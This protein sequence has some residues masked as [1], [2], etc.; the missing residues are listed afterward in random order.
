MACRE[1]RQSSRL[2]SDMNLPLGHKY[3][4]GDRNPC[5]AAVAAASELV[6][7][8]SLQPAAADPALPAPLKAVIAADPVAAA[9]R[10]GIDR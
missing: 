5:I 4:R 9:A 6:A 7:V 8:W 2:S 3:G 1:H 10:Q